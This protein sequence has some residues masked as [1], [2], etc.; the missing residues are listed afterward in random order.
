[1]GKHTGVS[2]FSGALVALNKQQQAGFLEV[3]QKRHTHT[4]R[5]KKIPTKFGLVRV[6]CFHQN[7]G[8]PSGF[9]SHKNRA[10]TAKED[11]PPPVI[12]LTQRHLL[13]GRSSWTR[14][15]SFEGLVS[16]T[17]MAQGQ[18]ETLAHGLMKS[19]CLLFHE[20]KYTHMT[21]WP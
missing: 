5:R 9:P 15:L 18:I 4:L 10:P 6:A 21:P 7:G 2:Y 13:R 12:R 19:D 14:Q 16:Q 17:E 20:M 3:P 8:L 1:M 11:E